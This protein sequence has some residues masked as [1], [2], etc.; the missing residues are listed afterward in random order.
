MGFQKYIIVAL[1]ICW[2]FSFGCSCVE[3]KRETMVQNGLASSDIVFYGQVIQLDSIKG[4]YTFKIFELFKGKHLS[5]TING[6]LSGGNCSV[7]PQLNDIWI[8]YSNT[9]E[10][11][12][13]DISMCSPSQ[14][15]YNGVGYY[16][17]PPPPSITE[18]TNKEIRELMHQVHEL[19]YQNKTLSNWFYQLDTLKRYKLVH[20][21]ANPDAKLLI[22]SLLAN[23]IL[24]L[25]IIGIIVSKKSSNKRITK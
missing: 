10:K 21:A 12:N 16:P 18:I 13:I 2:N 14:T 15:M 6:Q 1:L 4:S 5:K 11:G 25:T 23:A 3:Q 9:D 8:V 17:T 7:L 22:G 20:T 24:L 19:E